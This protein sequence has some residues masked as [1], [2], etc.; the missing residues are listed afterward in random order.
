MYS[1]VGRE[2]ATNDYGVSKSFLIIELGFAFAIEDNASF[3]DNDW[4]LAYESVFLL[5]DWLLF[6][7]ICMLRHRFI[8]NKPLR[9]SLKIIFYFRTL[10]F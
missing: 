4:I 8:N 6:M 1:I 7:S 2:E 10:F 9:K 3:W 5:C